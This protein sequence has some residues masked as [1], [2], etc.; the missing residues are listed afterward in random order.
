MEN[1][2]PQ[3]EDGYTKINNE[4]YEAT[5]RYS[6]NGYELRV[7]H[8]II[9]KTYGYNKKSDYIAYSQIEELTHIKK[10][11]VSRAVANLIKYQV[12]TKLGNE[13]GINKRLSE[14][15]VTKLGNAKKALNV[16]PKM[17]TP[18]P[19]MVKG[20]TKL[21]NEKL[22]KMEPQ[23]KKDNITKD[24]IQKTIGELPKMVTTELS[25][26]LGK[27]NTLF[28][29]EYRETDGRKKTLKKRLEHY[30]LEQI[31]K[32]TENLSTSEWHRGKNERG[33]KADPDFLIRNDEQI[34]KWLN[35]QPKKCFVSENL[36]KYDNLPVEV[37]NN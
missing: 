22:P 19:K 16:L 30:S 32:A 37:I 31:L 9:R 2:T 12:V 26:F 14:W 25:I 8:A 1:R 7:L 24:N 17:D 15:A 6:F 29:S 27:F 20:V 28:S 13:I 10:A 34:D 11:H 21:G 4:I 36:N 35:Y 33:W 23:N 5:L 3:L 18:L